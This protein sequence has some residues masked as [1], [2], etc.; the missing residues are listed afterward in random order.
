MLIL[1]QEQMF[2]FFNSYFSPGAVSTFSTSF[3]DAGHDQPLD[4]QA[5][6]LDLAF[7]EDGNP[8]TLT[9]DQIAIFRHSEIQSLLSERRKG[10]EDRQHDSEGQIIVP[11]ETH[12]CFKKG[13]TPGYEF[14]QAEEDGDSGEDEE[15]EYER[16]ILEE[17]LDLA[18][19]NY[20][21]VPL[22]TEESP[23]DYGDSHPKHDAERAGN[24]VIEARRIISYEDIIDSTE[25]TVKNGRSGSEK[26]RFIWPKI[27]N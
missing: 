22:A 10:L 17:S 11:E 15:M 7:Y 27:G 9:D 26:P 19:A 8:R 2:H 1:L 23:L 20:D 13:F 25:P 14:D 4:S 5:I 16:Y 24:S 12:G 3:L 21:K 18:R 6:D